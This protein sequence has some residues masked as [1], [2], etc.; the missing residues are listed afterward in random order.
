MHNIIFDRLRLSLG[1]TINDK[2]KTIY[3]QN[4]CF[5]FKGSFKQYFS[6]YDIEPSPR[7]RKRERDRKER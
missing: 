1:G 7:E 6:L 5:V 4:S 2:H 3:I